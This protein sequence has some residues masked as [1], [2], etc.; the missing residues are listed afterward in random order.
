MPEPHST[1][2]ESSNFQINDNVERYEDYK[3]YSMGFWPI[4]SEYLSRNDQ[5]NLDTRLKYQKLGHC[6]DM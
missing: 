4:F 5:Q 3:Q 6:P 2:V 1:I